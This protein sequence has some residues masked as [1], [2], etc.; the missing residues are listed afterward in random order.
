MAST[1]TR[2]HRRHA[3]AAVVA[4]AAS[5]VVVATTATAQAAD[6][7]DTYAEVGSSGTPPVIECSWALN[8]VD[9]DWNT[10]MDYG[11]DDNPGLLANYPCVEDGSAATQPDNAYPTIQVLPNA[12]DDPTEA[13]VELWAAVTSNSPNTNVY[14][15][16]YHPDGSFKVQIDGT[17]YANSSNP[18]ECVGPPG[19][20][21]AAA[22]NGLITQQ[23]RTNIIN[24]C[25]NQQKG[26]YYGAFG[27]SK[28]QPYGPYRIEVHAAKA[29]GT[30]AILNYYIDVLGF[31]QLEKD[32][33]AIDFG[34]VAPNSHFW[35]P[36]AGDFIWDGV[37]NVANAAST[38]RNTGN[39]GIGL[40][41]RF[42]SMCL[43][44]TND[45]ATGCTDDKRIDHFDAKFGARVI[46]NMQAIG[47]DSLGTALTSDL[48]SN[49]KP[50][51]PGAW[52]SFDNAPE[53]VLC[54][55][56]PGKIEFSIWTENIQGG[57]YVAPGGIGLLAQSVPICPT[58]LGAPYLANGY[59][60]DTPWSN[61][62]HGGS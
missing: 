61:T 7:A 5:S 28:H 30:E 51:P 59:T 32:F 34:P 44:T 46:G 3:I 6:D 36:T 12:H 10:L 43:S 57:T 35:Q 49:A 26:L 39:A 15:D 9:H 20:F 54:P 14:F 17:R 23:A 4:L 47:N 19:M 40:S 50:A 38:V 48:A 27:I 16:V 53:R 8:D 31:Y 21:D 37:D 52:Y 25:Q 33:T 41:V 22:A 45:G 18:A 29:G 55:N 62:H 13:Y 1:I 42:R 2:R 11:L 24:E 58:D 56:D 60:G